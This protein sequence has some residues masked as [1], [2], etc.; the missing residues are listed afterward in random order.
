MVDA[1]TIGVLVTAASV[2]VAA[3]YYI[4]TLRV[5]QRNVKTNI[6]SRQI[7]LLTQLSQPAM[8][9]EGQK[10][11]LE[12]MN[13]EWKDYDDFE[14]KYGSDNNPDNYAIRYSWNSYFQTI[15]VLLKYGL[16][17]PDILY[18]YTG[19]TL[20]WA[21]GKYRGIYERMR[22]AYGNPALYENWEYAYNEMVRVA[23][24]R[25]HPTGFPGSFR[26]TEEMRR[27]VKS[28]A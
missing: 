2:T 12:Y 24:V 22:E 13:I 16:I 15:G 3:V 25:R 8:S 26:Y 9:Y 10:R 11:Y 14:N 27:K 18:D 4:M 17:E 7:Q 28:E 20:I 1:Q 21:W 5:Q 19:S 6:E 23:E